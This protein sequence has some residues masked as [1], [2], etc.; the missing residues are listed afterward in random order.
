MLLLCL[1]IAALPGQATAAPTITTTT[2]PNG[3]VNSSYTA[4]LSATGTAPFTWT[5]T[6]GALPPACIYPA[7]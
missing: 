5:L 2:L 1:S 4:M 3:Q 6:G 7:T